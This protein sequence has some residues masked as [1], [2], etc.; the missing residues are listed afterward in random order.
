MR[1]TRAGLRTLKPA[2]IA[3]THM[4]ILGLGYAIYAFSLIFQGTRWHSTP[5]Y[6][7]LLIIA[8]TGTWGA[9]FAFAALL[10]L[11]AAYRPQPEALAYT[12]V[13]L[14]FLITTLWA[15]AF[16]VRYSTSSSTTPETWVS[17]AVNDYL[18]LRAGALI[19]TE[20]GTGIPAA[21]GRR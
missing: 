4:L 13:M 18:L 20:R 14:A 12:A 16:V 10:L 5:A 8:P 1:R 9:V 2:G 7:N 19:H 21:Q 3:G 15:L 6:H 11:I 17:W